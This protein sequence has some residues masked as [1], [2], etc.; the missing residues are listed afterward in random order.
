MFK[1]H[2]Q[3]ELRY[4]LADAHIS[5]CTPLVLP[6]FTDN[7][8]YETWADFIRGILTNEDILGNTIYCHQLEGAYAAQISN[9]PM[10]DAVR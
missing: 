10:Y 6:L 2:G 8:D 9:V 4:D 7:F 1:E 5:I 3:V